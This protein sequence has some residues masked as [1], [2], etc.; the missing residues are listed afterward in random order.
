MARAVCT[1][2]KYSWFLADILRITSEHSCSLLFYYMS[3]VCPAT[4]AVRLQCIS[5]VISVTNPLRHRSEC[6]TVLDTLP[7]HLFQFRLECPLELEWGTIDPVLLSFFQNES[8]LRIVKELVISAIQRLGNVP[9]S[10]ELK[11]RMFYFP[12]LQHSNC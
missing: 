10:N 4:S 9:N 3:S 12:F 6:K 11:V 1:P 2:L 5:R 8:D 7:K